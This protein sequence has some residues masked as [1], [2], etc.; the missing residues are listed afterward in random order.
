MLILTVK[1]GAG[2]GLNPPLPIPPSPP[3][4]S[5]W[6]KFWQ[7]IITWMYKQEGQVNSLKL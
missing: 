6:G 2:G 1:L 3:L 7:R 5:F 4:R